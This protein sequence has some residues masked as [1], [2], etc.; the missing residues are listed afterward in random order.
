MQALRELR[1]PPGDTFVWIAA[2]SRVIREAR[3]HLIEER[4]HPEA[5]LKA[6]GYWKRGSAQGAD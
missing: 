2:E 3:L 5:W 4:G 1:F 6:A